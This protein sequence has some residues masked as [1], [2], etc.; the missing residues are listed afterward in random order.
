[1][2]ARTGRPR[3]LDCCEILHTEVVEDYLKAVFH[4]GTRSDGTATTSGLAAQLGVA[5]PSVSAML[6]RLEA[7]DLVRRSPDQV[8]LTAHGR[9]HA[10]D[11]VRRHRLL[12]VFLVQV[13]DVPWDEVHAE[14]EVLEHAL[15]PRLEARIDALLGHPTRDPHGDPIPPASGEHVEDWATPLALAPP[16]CD[17]HVERVSD[18]DSDALRHLAALG[19][20]PGSLLR[21]G[22]WAPFGGPLEVRAAGAQ[23]LLAPGLVRVVHGRVAS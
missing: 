1:M 23:H 22:D 7:D 20:G 17:F 5:A 12:E 19:I 10:L 8:E 13:L 18:R 2:G 6:K 14:A 21:V 4:E 16:G 9:R 11:V 3:D 15:S